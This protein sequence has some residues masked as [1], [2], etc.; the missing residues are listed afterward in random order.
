MRNLAQDLRYGFRMMK[1]RPGFTIIAVIALALGIGANS[2]LFSVVNAVM[3]KPLPYPHPERIMLLFETSQKLGI[4]LFP[5]SGPDYIDIKNQ[6]QIFEHV[7]AAGEASFNLTAEGTEPERIEGMATSADLF[8]LLGVQPLLGR[9]FSVDEEQ[10]GR[11]RVAVISY[12]LWQRRF[13]ANQNLVGQT[14][15]LDGQS[16]LV[17]GVMPPDFH[18]PEGEKM[19]IWVPLSFATGQENPRGHHD[20]YILGRLK[21]NVTMT[22]AQTEMDVI[23][24]RL[25]QQYPDT[26]QDWG[27]KVVSFQ[28]ALTEDIGPALYVLLAAVGFVLLIACT[29]VANLQ[30]A[31]ATARQ[32]EVAIRLAIGANRWRLMKQFLTESILLASLG[33]ALGLL[34]AYW[35]VDALVSILPEDVP[36]LEQIGI[37]RYVLGFTLAISVLTGILLG[38]APALQAT[39]PDLT[40]ALKESSRNL[41]GSFR[42]NRLRSLLVISEVALAL[43][44]LIGAGLMMKSFYHLRSV[45]PGFNPD[46]LLAVHLSLPEQKYEDKAEQAAFFHQLLERVETLPGVV[47]AGA[48]MNLP[49]T[50]DSRC[51]FS[52]E[53]QPPNAPGGER[54][55]SYSPASPNYFRTMGI[56]VVN[57][58]AFTEQDTDKT[59][60]VI[61]INET[62]AR[63]YFGSENPVGRRLKL[64]DPEEPLPWRTIVGVV[65]DVRHRSLDAAP[66]PEVYTPFLQD[67]Q[68]GMA[69]V[70]RTTSNPA[71]I[72]PAV[73]REVAAIDKE[74]PIYGVETMEHIVSQSIA[75][76]RLSVML[77]T[78]FALL[79]LVLAGVGIYGVISYT[80]SQR[81]H[82]VGIRMALGAQKKDILRLVVG[83]GMTL[84]LIGLAVGLAGAFALTR[85]MTSLLFEVRPTDPL[86]FVGL[87]VLLA[88]VSLI[89]SYI[90]ARRAAKVDPMVALRYE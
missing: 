27:I 13:G 20:L 37:D 18:F 48:A 11:N 78:L 9:P 61:I 69:L 54:L 79:A 70:V 24:S 77:L 68:G 38:M 35:G 59:T 22:E 2:A 47:S 83:Q 53:G 8:P 74:Q 16:Y 29:N 44:L 82:E 89:A 42:R 51:D 1:K 31:R 62:M 46:N 56:P 72:L 73:R 41:M 30:L 36:R 76:Q 43:L 33:G 40:E 63:Q 21:P 5:F 57:G 88:A 50:D 71:G 23:A 12:S 6:N 55:T 45:R 66:M 25:S 10:P 52:I 19:D 15:T 28:K 67:P 49:M 86:T 80:V 84:V 17:A 26:N 32:K 65:G 75:S 81:T 58:R 64:A 7:A 39:K 87:S 4:D 14:I 85:L 90:P 60:P 34:L 3:L